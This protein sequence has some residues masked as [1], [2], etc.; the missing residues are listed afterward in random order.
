MSAVYL[1]KPNFVVN[2][3]HYISF[4]RGR[5]ECTL[6]SGWQAFNYSAAIVF[7]FVRPVVVE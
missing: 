3:V 5:N 1:V 7:E 6:R 4:H 2:I